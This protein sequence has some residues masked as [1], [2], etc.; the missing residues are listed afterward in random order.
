M[1]AGAL[2]QGLVTLGIIHSR[3]AIASASSLETNF[4]HDAH[5]CWLIAFLMRNDKHAAYL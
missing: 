5:S 4:L 3:S 1:E 2:R